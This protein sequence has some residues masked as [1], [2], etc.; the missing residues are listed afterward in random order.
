MSCR[1]HKNYS[2]LKTVLFQ[3]QTKL[4]NALEKGKRLLKY[5]KLYKMSDQFLA[6]RFPRTSKEHLKRFK[7]KIIK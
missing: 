4:Q 5:L 7:I 2:E 3:C 6:A 1:K